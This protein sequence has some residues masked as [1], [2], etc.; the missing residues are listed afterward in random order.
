MEE[1]TYKNIQ[2]STGHVLIRSRG[3]DCDTQVTT[4]MTSQS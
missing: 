2:K 4:E 1:T 3:G